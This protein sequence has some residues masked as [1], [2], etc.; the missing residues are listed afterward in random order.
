MKFTTQTNSKLA[1]FLFWAL[2]SGRKQHSSTTSQYWVLLLH[3]PQPQQRE[4]K[5]NL[6]WLSCVKWHVCLFTFGIFMSWQIYIQVYGIVFMCFTNMHGN[7]NVTIQLTIHPTC[8]ICMYKNNGKSAF[9]PY[10]ELQMQNTSMGNGGTPAQVLKD[11]PRSWWIATVTKHQLDRQT[12]LCLGSVNQWSYHMVTLHN[13]HEPL[14]VKHL[15]NSFTLIKVAEGSPKL[16]NQT[17]LLC[18]CYKMSMYH[19]TDIPE[20]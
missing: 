13:S 12:R 7:E 5:K 1:F 16:N 2:E 15:C 6:F 19:F 18:M 17:G 11:W 8:N 4:K 14:L 9:W 3:A 20:S 10:L